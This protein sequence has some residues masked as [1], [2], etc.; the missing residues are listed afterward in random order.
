MT[1][2]KKA[3]KEETPDFVVAKATQS[4]GGPFKDRTGRRLFVPKG[5]HFP[6]DSDLVK[7]FPGSFVTVEEFITV[8][9]DR[10]ESRG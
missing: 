3:T 9:K 7:A 2:T 8:W 6:G 5:E 10:P 4:F 1:E